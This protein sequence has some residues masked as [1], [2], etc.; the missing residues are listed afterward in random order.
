MTIE[1]LFEQDINRTIKGV[2]QVGQDTESIIEQEVKE[3]VITKE[4]KK[5]F[6]SFFDYY[7][8]AFNKP[9]SDV[10]VWISG[11]FGSGKSH[12]LKMLS[13]ILENKIIN[14]VS[15]VE[16]FREKFSDDPMAF[17]NIDKSTRNKTETIL[18][19]IGVEGSINK[20]ETVVLRVFAKM[21]FKHLGFHGDDLDTALLEYYIDSQG[22]T[23]EF[24][25]N[26]EAI[27][28]MPWT[29]VR[30]AFRFNR[31]PIVK[32]LTQTLDIT[33][34]DARAWFDGKNKA[35]YSVSRFV[36]DVKTYV[37]KQ[38][39]DYRLLFMVDEV[40]QYVGADVNL[41]LDLQ[42]I[43][44]ELG[45]KCEGKVWVVCTGQEAVDEIIK[46]RMDAFS[47]ILDRFRIR[48][49]I[50]SSSADEVIQKRLLQKNPE[51]AKM[52]ERIY[53]ANDSVLRNLFS[54]SDTRTDI[55]GYSSSA[56]YVQ[57]YPF[58]PYQFT[59]IQKV[60][61]E[62]RKHGNAG[63]NMSDGA[64]SMLS[65][66]Q[67]SAKK[68][69][70]NDEYSLVPF[71]CFYDAIHSSLDS[72][73][74]RVVERC[75]KAAEVKD[76]IEADD[77]K[78]LKILYLIRYIS[79]DIKSTLDNI[80]ILMADSIKV[81]KI[82]LR[83]KVR[84]SLDRLL[85]ENYIGRSGD[86]YNFLTDE[87]QDIQ[88]DIAN[89]LVDTSATVKKIFDIIFG[90]IYPGKKFR[91]GGKNDFFYDQAVDGVE[92]NSGYSMKIKFLTSAVDETEKQE[93]RLRTESYKQV[94]VVL[95][96]EFSYFENLEK[97]GKV[98]KYVK[99]RN[100]SQLAKSVQDI[101]RG[102]Q[103]EATK[104]ES[105]ATSLITKAIEKA[106]FYVA[107]EKLDITSG[108]A[109]SK[110]DQ[111]FSYLVANVYNKLELINHSISSDM[112]IIS[113]LRGDVQMVEGTEY[114]R[115]AA[116]EVESYLEMQMLSH[117]PTSMADIQSRYKAAPY[118]WLENEIAYVVAML[119]HG[120][121]VTIKYA[122]ETIQPNNP[123]LLDMLTKRSEIGKTGISK[124]QEIPSFMV[125]A[126]RSFLRDYFSEMN[127][128]ADDDGLVAY[129]K[130]KFEERRKAYSEILSRYENCKYPD[131]D[132][133]FKA[134][135]LIDE[136]LSQVK[137][138]YALCNK[139]K[140]LSNALLDSK[141]D[142]ADI[143]SF[144]KN[145]VTLFDTAYK[146]VKDL[147]DEEDYLSH[148]EEAEAALRK[149][150]VIIMVGNGKYDYRRIPELNSLIATVNAEHDKLL[151][152]K[153][154]EI[155]EYVRQCMEAIHMADEDGLQ[156][157]A[158]EIADNYYD[159]QKEKIRCARSLVVL[160]GLVMPMLQYKDEAVKNIESRNKP[161]VPPR[162]KSENPPKKV[163]KQVIRSVVFPARTL[164]SESEIDK[165]V[166]EVRANLKNLLGNS[167]GINIK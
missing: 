28:G 46:V 59:L 47:R 26:I 122:G 148:N 68:V 76:G 17:L 146:L 134:V 92:S 100:P 161:V 132:I 137:D 155:L 90:D 56:E 127:I 121:K 21:F 111:A 85:K 109:K 93:I 142:I 27:K 39:K 99:Q 14:G 11:F 87:E 72:P 48:L 126:V 131:Y 110:I 119:I 143:E 51:A 7:S 153:R 62:I 33:E 151:E 115:E 29:E 58:V 22:K 140:S 97:S 133:V 65:G 10:G 96:D 31:T 71:N 124:R 40:G 2:V 1:K 37:K 162:G 53:D 154:E 18:F 52:L 82:I 49:A 150:R 12:F 79:D 20:D 138:N 135:E 118:G 81:D 139:V 114:N 86:T 5:H 105:E 57:D 15:T 107:G 164:G 13:Y 147:R 74:R 128:P 80:V 158:I 55:K 45:S 35:E 94:I 9:T 95:S 106:D 89:T 117:H 167:D 157:D 25:K 123:K 104:L 83:E 78:V 145:Q 160:D 19:D 4:L 156:K 34:E 63:C 73:I 112:E 32:A 136:V 24:R 130:A 67:E 64:R 159:K 66:F 23:E 163:Y 113:V 88:R 129:I 42:S 50:S 108:D 60:Y 165:Y 166:E 41:L 84:S 70:N 75:E 16:R 36:E 61:T 120:Q 91:Y 152:E 77:V 69:R 38:P 44:S 116:A 103:D 141:E 6:L 43:V 3:Y 149:I 98:R 125:N 144:F 101:I 8:E 54:F 102:H 30:K